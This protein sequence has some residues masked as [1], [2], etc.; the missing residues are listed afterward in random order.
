MALTASKKKRPDSAA[1]LRRGPA[2]GRG[3]SGRLSQ[4]S[5]KGRALKYLAQREHSRHELQ[6]KLAPHAESAE[7]LQALLDDLERDKFLSAPRFVE[8]LV[9]RRVAR[10]GIRRIEQELDQ[11]RLPD[12]TTGP[13]LLALRQSERDRALEVW[14]KRFGEPPADLAERGR[15]QRFL[16]Q[17]GFEGET[18]AWVFK[19]ASDKL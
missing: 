14:R 4:L 6:R 1:G 9:R 16:A 18:I 17:R 19:R 3:A 15:Q 2:F 8:S 11:H 5:L 7:Q 10:F 12:E 13:A